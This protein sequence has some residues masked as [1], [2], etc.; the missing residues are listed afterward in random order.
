MHKEKKHIIVLVGLPGSGKSTFCQDWL[1]KGY[2]ARISQ[3]EMGKQ[4][5]R[6]AFDKALQY[7]QNIII[8]R[9]NFNVEQ[10]QRYIKPAREKGYEV[11]V[12]W[13]HTSADECIRRIK[14]RKNH[15]NLAE[16]NEKIEEVVRMFDKMFVAP[17]KWEYDNLI[18]MY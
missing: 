3:D 15:P 8:D 10:R 4:G 12:V 16:G 11:H 18:E 7:D 6:D 13:F 1:K 2:Y 14:M 5:H 9:C 17:E